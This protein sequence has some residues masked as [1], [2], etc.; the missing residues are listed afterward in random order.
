[1]DLPNITEIEGPH[2]NSTNG[3][4]S[5][6]KED[7]PYFDVM[8]IVQLAIAPIGIVGNLTVIAVFLSHRKLRSKILNRLIINQVRTHRSI[9]IMFK[10]IYPYFCLRHDFSKWS[11]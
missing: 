3:S 10:C 5:H 1:M 7:V 9:N 11:S 2:T 4:N 6:L 8:H